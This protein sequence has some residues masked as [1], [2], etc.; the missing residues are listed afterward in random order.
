MREGA[1]R[2]CGDGRALTSLYHVVMTTRMDAT[3]VA[4]D[5]YLDLM[6][7]S[8]TGALTEDNDLILG[9]T[10]GVPGL[11]YR[12]AN[13]VGN[14]FSSLGFELSRKRP[15][16][17][18]LRETGRDWPVRAESMIGLQRMDN[19]R[20]C[21]EAA[22]RDDVPGDV[23]ETG[24]WRGGAT[25]FMR[26]V[27][28][29]RGDASRRVWVADSFEGLPPPDPRR[30]PADAGDKHFRFQGLH[31][32]VEQVKENF[33]RYGLLDDQ[34]H[35]LVGWFKDTLHSAPIDKLAV[36]RLDG[37]LYES[38]IQ[39]L[40][41]LYPKLS[42]GGFCIVDDYGYM[43]SC[44]RAIHDYRQTHNINEPIL[45]IDGYGIYWRKAG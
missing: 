22:L 19:I 9:A 36:L 33:R 45:D 17:A 23:I 2:G 32:G 37:D 40:D 14:A 24:V 44:K 1:A 7:R 43:D 26:A 34:V 18:R 20:H 5:L 3:D 41:A 42:A 12:I 21:I 29:A 8:L 28:K 16:D 11:K 35:F 25:I 27:L 4:V 31:I 39:S 30:Y 38:T 13:S 15:F 6:K 10:T